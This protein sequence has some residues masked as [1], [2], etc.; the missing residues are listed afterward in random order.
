[1]YED[2]S[3]ISNLIS[4]VYLPTF[5]SFF[6]Y[7]M[8]V[9]TPTH[10]VFRNGF[11]F[12][13]V[14]P[15]VRPSTWAL[16]L[17]EKT[18]E[19]KKKEEAD[20]FSIMLSSFVDLIRVSCLFHFYMFYT[21]NLTPRVTLLKQNWGMATNARASR[22]GESWVIGRTSMNHNI[23]HRLKWML[24]GSTRSCCQLTLLSWSCLVNG[25]GSV[26][27]IWLNLSLPFSFKLYL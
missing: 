23:K 4:M 26:W 13:H 25:V 6:K 5:V 15:W 16:R 1:M 10:G 21:V 22:R 2:Q 12:H 24:V 18:E 3:Q 11:L 7:K 20:F 8:Y 9:T 17:L 19:R 14:L 27:L